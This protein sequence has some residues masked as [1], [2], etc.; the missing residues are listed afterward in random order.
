MFTFSYKEILDIKQ[1]TN[2]TEFVN[3]NI[4][5]FVN[6]AIGSGCKTIIKTLADELGFKILDL[7]NNLI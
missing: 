3:K 6:G 1:N 2:M 7:K 5:I 4:W